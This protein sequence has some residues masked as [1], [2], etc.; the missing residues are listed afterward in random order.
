MP[1]RARLASGIP[2]VGDGAIG[3]MLFERGLA[4]GACPESVTLDHP[5]WL[6][7]IA[8]SYLRAGADILTTNTFGGS[9]LK[10]APYGLHGRCEEI[11]RR[12]VELLRGVAG[13]GAY[14][15]GS[16]GPTGKLIKPYGDTDAEVI[17]ASFLRQAES[18]LA[19]GVDCVFVETMMDVTEATSAVRAVKR[20]SPS[21][22]V[23]AAMT[24]DATPGGFFTIMGVSVEAAVSELG[25]VGADVV[26]SN[27]G[28]GSETMVEIARAFRA[29]THLPLI[30]QS[31]AG[32]P[33]VT[34]DGTVYPE[35]PAF[36]AE[37]AQALVALG[38]TIIGGCCGT[39]PA[40]IREVGRAVGRKPRHAEV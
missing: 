36:M 31:N 8:D 32:L 10:L 40:H 2:L 11:N 20:L 22:P 4:P 3:T 30:I 6:V 23:A 17:E 15:A 24:F 29:A 1:F 18:L 33:Q 14:V 5:E 26:G 12:G 9:D 34:G 7:E 35:T 16:I 25:D 39:T 19:A 37:K 28:N 38:V 27:C 13:N 21:T